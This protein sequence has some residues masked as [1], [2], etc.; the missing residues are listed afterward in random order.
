MSTHSRTY[1]QLAHFITHEMRMSHI[2]QPV[3][4]RELL[5]HRGSG[6]VSKIAKALLN[7]DRAQ[8]E[9]YEQITKNMVGRVLTTNRRITERNDQGY[10]LKNFDHLSKSEVNELIELCNEKIAEYLDKRRDP[11]S[12]RR[13]SIGYISG[14][15]RYEIF[16]RAGTR[17][18][19]CGISNEDKALEVD[20]IIPRNKG[21]TDDLSN[22]QA[23]CYSCNAMKRDRDD[24]DFHKMA[25]RY[26]DR[27]LNCLFC[28]IESSR[29]I[30]D[31]ELCQAI[32][33]KY[34]VSPG[35]TLIIPKRHVSNFFDLY[36]P[37]INA[38]YALLKNAKAKIGDVDHEV[39]GFNIGVN[40]GE[41]AGQTVTHAHVHLIPRRNADVPNPRG[42]VRGVIPSKQDYRS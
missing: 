20:H 5:L 32:R 41:D 2:Y 30:L 28:N 34:P 13:K 3:M 33:D 36:Q 21:G 25:A 37:E 26:Q 42:G 24:T 31:N 14:T 35:H 16:K 38:I 17:C 39:T 11:W 15:I 8:I 6:S 19:A 22:L 4:L 7:E 29:I 1:E 10:R 27:E 9:Y 18:E 40:I 23:L 12:H